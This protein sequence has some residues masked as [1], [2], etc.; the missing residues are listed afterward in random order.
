M[1]EYRVALSRYSHS[2]RLRTTTI[3]GFSLLLLLCMIIGSSYPDA[4]SYAQEAPSLNLNDCRD[5][6]TI[7]NLSQSRFNIMDS[8]LDRKVSVEEDPSTLLDAFVELAKYIVTHHIVS[9]VVL[10]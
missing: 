1:L 2:F 5:D 10:V 6:V 9:L 4:F 8:K 3:V 7:D